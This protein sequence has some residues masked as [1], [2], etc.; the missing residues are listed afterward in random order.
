[1]TKARKRGGLG[2]KLPNATN[3]PLTLMIQPQKRG[4]NKKFYR[5]ICFCIIGI[6][7]YITTSAV[8]DEISES[9]KRLNSQI[10]SA[11]FLT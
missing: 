4:P 3:S 9:I 11:I 2:V 10:Q 8:M 6:I 5:P 7:I 1:M